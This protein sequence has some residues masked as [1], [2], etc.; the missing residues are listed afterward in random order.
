M[1]KRLQMKRGTA[2]EWKEAKEH[3]L[4]EGDIGVEIDTHKI[5]V[6]NGINMYSELPYANEL[7]WEDF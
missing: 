2:A 4:A 7:I 5:K 6:G 3:V 1:A